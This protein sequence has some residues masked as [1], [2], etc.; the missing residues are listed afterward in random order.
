MDEKRY[1][2]IQENIEK[3]I[4]KAEINKCKLDIPIYRD[5]KVILD[6][7]LDYAKKNKRII[8][9]GYAQDY[10]L[11]KKTKKGLYGN[12]T[13]GDVDMKS[14]DPVKDLVQ[15]CNQIY[16]KGFTNI[17]GRQSILEGVFN[18][19]VEGEMVAD[20]SYVSP[21]AEDKHILVKKD[22]G[23]IYVDYRYLIGD[24]Y[25]VFTKHHYDYKKFLEK[26]F[27]RFHLI[28]KTFPDIFAKPKGCGSDKK[29]I[30]QDIVKYKKLIME[31]YIY[32]N[33]N[34]IL[35]GPDAYFYYHQLSGYSKDHHQPR[36]DEEM[37]IIVDDLKQET[38]KIIK[39]LNLKNIKLEEY[40]K[41]L[42]NFD[43]SIVIKHKNKPIIRI[44]DNLDYCTQYNTIESD[45]KE[46][47]QIVSY[48]YMMYYL[49][50]MKSYYHTQPKIQQ[51][52]NCMFYYMHQ[53]HNYY[54]KKNNLVGYEEDNPFTY[55]RIECKWEKRSILYKRQQYFN[56]RFKDKKK[57]KFEYRPES[58]F[59]K[60]IKITFP[61][62]DNSGERITERRQLIFKEDR[63]LDSKIKK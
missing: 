31:E 54:L 18:I 16:E 44:Y 25:F 39:L 32:N 46:K 8:Y 13:G 42:Y 60:E 55:F 40:H 9:G 2:E 4:E 7:I 43:R 35:S 51:K 21:L 53:F 36:E 27:K 28:T 22:K 24:M 62:T 14:P 10:W 59:M 26:T 17:I 15:I 58:N 45:N 11:K 33:E 50:Y 49:I 20:V 19:I 37:V 63:Y 34:V 48:S 52:Y 56:Q 5:K 3:V 23:F 61:C 30:D 1:K 6:I 12:T 57:V 41:I 38:K 47:I 29:K